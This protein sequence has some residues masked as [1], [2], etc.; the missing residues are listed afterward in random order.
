MNVSYKHRKTWVYSDKYKRL[1]FFRREFFRNVLKAMKSN[2]LYPDSSLIHYKRVLYFKIFSKN[3]V[4]SHLAFFRRSCLRSGTGKSVYRKFK[5]S[6]H[7][8]KRL[9][10]KGYLTGI[11]KSSY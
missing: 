4:N 7:E 11:S 3:S 8:A 5:Y 10:F 9:F 1:I 6:R 2:F